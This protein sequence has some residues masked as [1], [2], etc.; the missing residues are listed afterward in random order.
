MEIVRVSGVKGQQIT[1]GGCRDHQVRSALA[2]P[3]TGCANRCADLAVQPRC[4]MVIRE[5]L[6]CRLHMLKHS[7]AGS[8]LHGIVGGMRTVGQLTQ[9]DR[10]YEEGLGQFRCVVQPKS[11][12]DAG[13][14]HASL[15]R[16]HMPLPWYGSRRSWASEASRSARSSSTLIIGAVANTARTSS[17]GTACR[18]LIGIILASGSP[19]RVRVYEC[20]WRRPRVTDPESATNC[21]TLTS[22]GSPW[23]LDGDMPVVYPCRTTAY[24]SVRKGG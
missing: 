11:R 2:R 21:R 9:R 10:R 15:M 3:T 17:F 18:R 24:H 1:S 23:P 22:A 19:F 8:A 14:K 13:V 20:P 4:M 16:G 12:N 5:R 6:E 7:D